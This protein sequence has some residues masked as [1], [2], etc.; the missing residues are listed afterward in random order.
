MGCRGGEGV[1]ALRWE[2]RGEKDSPRGAWA[3]PFSGLFFQGGY[4]EGDGS[5][6]DEASL[7]ASAPGP[8][9]A[10]SSSPQSWTSTAG[11][12]GLR[13]AAGALVSWGGVSELGALT[14]GEESSEGG[15]STWGKEGKGF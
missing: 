4:E 11:A 2:L 13:G 15:R 6:E 8:G 5:A 9:S 1:R 10:A 3:G 12:S 7:L 14:Q